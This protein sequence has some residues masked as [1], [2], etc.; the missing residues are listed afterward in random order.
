MG[1]YPTMAWCC[2]FKLDTFTS[3]LVLVQPRNMSWVDW[4]KKHEKSMN[5]N[6]QTNNKLKI[7][8]IG[9]HIRKWFMLHMDLNV[10]KKARLKPSCLLSYRDKLE[11]PKC[12]SSK[13][14]YDTF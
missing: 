11:N 7:V 2:N 10:Y 1:S 9:Q 13:F 12:T 8:L 5:S 4:D 6:K 14:R 3:V